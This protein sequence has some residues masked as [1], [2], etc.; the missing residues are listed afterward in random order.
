LY[1]IADSP[2]DLNRWQHLDFPQEKLVFPLDFSGQNSEISRRFNRTCTNW[3]A[4][5]ISSHC[6]AVYEV[7][8]SLTKG[9]NDFGNNFFK[10]EEKW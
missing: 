5:N 3:Q 2:I 6:E 1:C 9:E 8:P 4:S 7:V 10:G